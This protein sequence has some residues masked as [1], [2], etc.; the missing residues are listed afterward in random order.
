MFLNA[1][2]GD[3]ALGLGDIHEQKFGLKRWIKKKQGMS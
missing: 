1:V 3:K 2:A